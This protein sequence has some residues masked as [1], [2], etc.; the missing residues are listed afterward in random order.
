VIAI[1]CNMLMVIAIA[2]ASFMKGSC[3][4]HIPGG[5][6]LPN[7]QHTCWMEQGYSQMSDREVTLLTPQ[8]C[9]PYHLS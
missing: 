5:Y 6:N 8:S 4:C 9:D 3:Q 1:H 2:V 7:F